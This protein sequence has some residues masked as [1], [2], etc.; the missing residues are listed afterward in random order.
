MIQ[1]VCDT[2]IFYEIIG[3]VIKFVKAIS[4]IFFKKNYNIRAFLIAFSM[5]SR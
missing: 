2:D 4:G 1:R 3:R 5:I